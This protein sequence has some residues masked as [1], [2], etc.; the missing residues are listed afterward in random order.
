VVDVVR[1]APDGAS[2]SVT[3]PAAAGTVKW[4]SAVRFTGPNFARDFTI[5]PAGSQKVIPQRILRD[6][7]TQVVR[8]SGF[9]LVVYEAGDRSDSVL[10]IAGPYHEAETW[11]GGPAPRTGV[12]NR[13]I[14][15]LEFVDSPTGARLT[16][17][18]GTNLVQHGVMVVGSD[19]W[20]TI[21]IKDAR[22]ERARVPH[23]RGLV[24]GDAEV[25]R[26]RMDLREEQAAK[27]AGTP[28]E[29]RYMYA[30]PT[31]VFD[32]AFR[33]QPPPGV[34]VAA[35]ANEDVNTVLAGLRVSWAG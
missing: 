33:D 26:Y 29:W 16:A 11:F 30:N 31:A 27:L 6:A 19:A 9:D 5:S 23:F 12:L 10:V 32:V 13:M 17:R 35:P 8:R 34:A 28:F 20:M 3:I 22:Q 4:H 24:Q 2:V 15:M 25:W 18:P 7:R 1:T 21:M 14:S